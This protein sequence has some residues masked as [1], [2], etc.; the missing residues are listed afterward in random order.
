MSVHG[1]VNNFLSTLKYRVANISSLKNIDSSTRRASLELSAWH[2]AFVMTVFNWID[3]TQNI[4]A[5]SKAACKPYNSALL[6][7]SVSMLQ[8][9][10]WDDLLIAIHKPSNLLVHRTELD[11]H[12]TR[13]AIQM[14]RDQIGRRVYPVHRLDKGTSGALLFALDKDAGRELSLQFE[15]QQVYKRYLAVVRGHPE[16]AGHIDHPL[17][18][19][20]DDLEWIGEKVETAPQ[21]AVTDYRTLARVELPIMV[22]RYPTSRYSL[23]ELEPQT[24]RKHQLRRHLKHIA[25]PIIGDS[26]H[27][28]GR[29]NRMFADQL[30]CRRMLL[31]CVEMRLTHPITGQPLL[32]NCPLESNFSALLA[33]LGWTDAARDAGIEL[34]I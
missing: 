18:R 20:P 1:A 15:R 27:G 10:Y 5:I 30:D 31:A 26:T 8:I 4:T 22:E 11:R 6:K 19:R 13:F 14:L 7:I 24:G 34:T 29:H 25:H 2:A 32:L 33:R 23:L 3:P 21:P 9:L 17:S 28:K 12:E 16:D